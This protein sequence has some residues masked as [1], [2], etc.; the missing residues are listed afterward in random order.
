MTETT[1]IALFKK[2]LNIMDLQNWMQGFEQVDCPI[3]HNFADHTY[4]RE[5]F[6]PAGTVVLGKRHRYETTNILMQGEISIFM[7]RDMPVERMKAPK[8]FK[9]KPFVKKLIYSHT[10]VIMCNVHAAE[11][12]DIEKIEADV[13]ITEEEFKQLDITDYR[14]FLDE[15]KL[16]D[17]EIRQH[18]ENKEDQVQMPDGE[19]KF[20]IS[21][22]SIEGSGTF[23]TDTIAAGETIGPSK[24]GTKRTPLGRYGN[25]AFNPNAKMVFIDGDVYLKA[26][27]KI[28]KGHEI[29]TSYRD[30]SKLFENSKIEVI[31]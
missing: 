24:I 28:A 31:Q 20:H 22:S 6:M 9:S 26:I 13:I 15:N 8:I 16:C 14:S 29:T 3:T 23:A 30:T 10:D 21:K 4:V 2:Q 7:G 1:D 27:D 18:V 17:D 12:D 11:T 5:M 19:Y 25:H